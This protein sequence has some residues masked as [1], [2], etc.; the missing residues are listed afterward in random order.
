MNPP[1]PVATVRCPDYESCGDPIRHAL[2]LSGLLDGLKGRKVLLKPNMMKGTP[3]ERAEATHPAFV[4]ALV[5]VLVENECQVTVGDSTGILGFTSEVF[6][7]SGMTAAVEKNGGQVVNFDAGPFVN[8]DLGGRWAGMPLPVARALMDADAVLDVP[9]MKTHT[10]LGLTLSVKNFVGAFPGAVKPH[11]HT[12]APDRDDFAWLV[13]GIP[14]ALT[15][16]GANLAGSIVDG[17]LALGGRGGNV[18]AAPTWMGYAV[19]GR[20]LFDVDMICAELTGFDPGK[21]PLCRIGAE[22]GLGH[23]AAADIPVV[24][25]HLRPVRLTAPGLDLQECAAPVTLAYYRVR[26]NL[27]KPVHEPALCTDC[28]KCVDV[29]PADCIL[30]RGPK[31][32]VIGKSCIRCLACREVCPSGAM[33]LQANRCLKPFLKKRTQGL[34][35]GRLR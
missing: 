28:N 27:V 4:G 22:R 30:V 12:L 11:L 1:E 26:G 16:A 21:I 8:I 13:S 34:D 23:A 6:D 32:R 14:A 25:D 5:A 18:P 19:A 35:M 10:F 29:C 3:P 31:D 24:G 7:A 20:N 9:K 15:A 33:G 2:E 17:V